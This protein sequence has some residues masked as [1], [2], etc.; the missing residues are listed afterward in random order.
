MKYKVLFVLFS[1]AIIRMAVSV[2]NSTS[3]VIHG[4]YSKNRITCLLEL[5]S[6]QWNRNAF[7]G[8]VVINFSSFS[9]S[10]G[11]LWWLHLKTPLWFHIIWWGI[12]LLLRR[13]FIFD[14]FVCLFIW[15]QSF[16]TKNGWGRCLGLPH[17]GCNPVYSDSQ[18]PNWSEL[19][20]G[21]KD[22]AAFET[23]E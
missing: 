7:F 23:C 21:W 9:R 12:Y 1:S 22:Q 14:L 5:C 18:I 16:T 10:L 19:W 2:L 4:R 11:Y 13:V 3:Y 6:C 20:D 8:A 15:S 17:A